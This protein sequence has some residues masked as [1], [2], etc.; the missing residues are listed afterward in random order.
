VDCRCDDALFFIF[1]SV[2]VLHVDNTLKL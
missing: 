2:D 1:V